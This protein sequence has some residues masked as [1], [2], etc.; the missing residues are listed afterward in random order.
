MNIQLIINGR[1]GNQFFQYATVYAFMR[2]NK[3][4]DVLKISIQ[5]L[6][7][8]ETDKGTFIDELKN[9]NVD[10]YEIISKAKMTLKQKIL[11]FLYRVTVKF[12]RKIKKMKKQPL[13]YKDYEFIDKIW[14]KILNYNG[15]YYYMPTN[16]NFYE[17][18]NPN[19][20]FYGSFENKD[21]FDKYREEILEMFEP[22]NEKKENN[23]RLIQ[24][25][26]EY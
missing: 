13:D 9:F 18:K 16:L 20:I 15:L 21:F 1:A 24:K 25:N 5:D 2:E 17:S 19:I 4:K 3:I 14:H 6:K 8:R 7:K 26:R 12:V 10:K 23:L 11:D 22:Q